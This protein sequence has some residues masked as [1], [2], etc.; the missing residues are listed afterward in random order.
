MCTYLFSHLGQSISTESESV[1]ETADQ[2]YEQ[3]RE[4]IQDYEEADNPHRISNSLPTELID[5]SVTALS[6]LIETFQTGTYT[7]KLQILTLL[8]S[9]WTT[10]QI[11]KYF[12]ATSHMIRLAHE[13]LNS[14]G[15]LA[16]PDPKKGMLS[17]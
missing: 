6:R 9:N 2:D 1:P 5:D 11:K 12:D 3:R 15:I 10:I 17:C 8:P 16:E 13:L 4:I 7:Q 14:R